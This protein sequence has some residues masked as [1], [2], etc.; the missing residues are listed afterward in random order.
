MSVKRRQ[1][2][3]LTT[4][5]FFRGAEG[6]EE[7]IFLVFAHTVASRIWASE[8]SPEKKLHVLRVLVL[9]IPSY[10]THFPPDID[11]YYITLPDQ[12]AISSLP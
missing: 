9:N 5:P 1:N 12:R 8:A 11:S 2:P 6:A 3:I 7:E 10:Y 4:S